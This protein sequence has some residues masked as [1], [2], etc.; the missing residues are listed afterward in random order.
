MDNSGRKIWKKEN[1]WCAKQ[2]N[3]TG[4]K[5]GKETQKEKKVKEQKKRG[6]DATT[7]IFKGDRRH[8]DTKT[9]TTRNKSEVCVRRHTK[10]L[11]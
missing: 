7:G 2:I 10:R 4:G 8:I 6:E 3:R 5:R 1:R 11:N 9:R